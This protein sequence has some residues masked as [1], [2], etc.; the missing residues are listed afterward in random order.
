MISGV[1]LVGHPYHALGMGEHLRQSA[2]AYQAVGIPNVVINAFGQLSEDA[3]KFTEF[4]Y[5]VLS[6]EPQYD[7]S[8]FHMNADEMAQVSEHLGKGFFEG[9]Y[10]IGYWLWELATFPD[11]WVYAFDHFDEI[12]APSRF[13]Q[14]AVS[15]KS[16]IPVKWV[17]EVVSFPLQQ[18]YDRSYFG[19]PSE[20][21]VF[22]FFFDF[23]SYRSRKNPEA[24]LEAFSRA[25]SQM[26]K[27]VLLLIKVNGHRS[28]PE[29]FEAFKA[30]IDENFSPLQVR[31]IAE[32]FSDFEMKSLMYNIDCFIS[33]HRSEGF[34][35]GLAEAMCLRKTVICTAYSGN[36]DFCLSNTALLVDYEMVDLKPGDYPHGLGCQWAEPDLDHAS[37][38]MVRAVK[39]PA[40]CKILTESAYQLIEAQHGPTSVGKKVISRLSKIR[41]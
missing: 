14:H 25:R 29:D 30:F 18:P 13:I 26:G 33:L 38:Q 11:D 6:D 27:D 19:I 15:E 22:L 17:P 24:V 34:G 35:R 41:V 10:N 37:Y 28:R 8:V 23:T 1:N 3:N 40:Y 36:T 2:L 39:D 9:R 20:K 16:P 32:V 21:Y 7:V 12:W 4:D 5:S 31:L